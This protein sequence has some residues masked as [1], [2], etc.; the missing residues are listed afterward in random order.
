[1]SPKEEQPKN[2]GREQQAKSRSL[3]WSCCSELEIAVQE[4]VPALD[5]LF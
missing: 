2:S 1:M 4:Q 5:L 3:L